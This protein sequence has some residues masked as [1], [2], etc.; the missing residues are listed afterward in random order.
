MLELPDSVDH[1]NNSMDYEAE[2]K[3][4]CLN[5]WRYS[6]NSE[7][8]CYL[9]NKQENKDIFHFI[10][11]CPILNEYRWKWFRKNTLNREEVISYLNGKNWNSL[12]VQGKEA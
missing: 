3:L 8:N 2:G 10:G 12:I 6:S 9:C 7:I 11:L 1:F 4:L 5:Y